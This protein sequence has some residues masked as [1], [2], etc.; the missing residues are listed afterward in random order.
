MIG[1]RA[2]SP[3][4]L[5]SYG[6]KG[7][8]HEVRGPHRRTLEHRL[9]G[10]DLSRIYP[11]AKAKR[12]KEGG[13]W[14]RVIEYELEGVEEAEALY[15]LIT[16]L[17]DAQT[18]PAHELAG[19]Y[20]ER[21]EIETTLDEFKTHMRGG[22]VVLRSKTPELV[23]QE[24]CGMMLAHRAVRVFMNEAALREN[25]DPDRLSFTHSIRVIRRKLAAISALPP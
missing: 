3:L 17:L 4:C 15:R 2:D 8:D 21:W 12:R 25:L 5:G 18:Y 14:V 24:F 20:E 16:T 23:S 22:R 13:I 11:S 7:N 9:A 6:T 1:N 19:L 10:P